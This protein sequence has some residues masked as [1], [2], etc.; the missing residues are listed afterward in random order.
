M[1]IT[2]VLSGCEEKKSESQSISAENTTE[3]FTTKDKKMQAAKNKTMKKQNADTYIIK[4]KRLTHKITI[5]NNKI[6]FHDIT[7]GVVMLKLYK[8]D[9]TLCQLQ[10]KPLKKLAKTHKKEFSILHIIHTEGNKE[11]TNLSNAIRATL[12]I[13]EDNSAPLKVLYKNGKYYSHFEGAIPIEM[14]SHDI[15][16]AIKK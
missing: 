4:D 5:N 11:I 14:I 15:L 12:G 2:L 16:E 7:T 13:K 6:T 10:S 3:I 8:P 9:C 1:C